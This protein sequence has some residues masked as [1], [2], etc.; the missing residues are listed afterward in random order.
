MKRQFIFDLRCEIMD[1]TRWARYLQRSAY[2]ARPEAPVGAAADAS[3][4]RGDNPTSAADA[5]KRCGT[6]VVRNGAA[7]LD[8]AD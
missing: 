7:N 8:V 2:A 6:T 1:R 3:Y 5:R 4:Q